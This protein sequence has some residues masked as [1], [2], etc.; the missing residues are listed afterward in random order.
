MKRKPVTLGEDQGTL[1]EG[2]IQAGEFS[3]R[4]SAVRHCLREYFANHLVETAA[5]LASHQELDLTD[6]AEA[7]DVDRQH[8]AN[9]VAAIDEDAAP[10][11]VTTYLA[12]IESEFP[13]MPS[14][15]EEDT[16]DTSEQEEQQ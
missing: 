10:A 7:I 2:A 15:D 8:L 1:I 5:L 12:E 13:S 16:A 3:D 9:L 11:E 14:E 6:V 4:S